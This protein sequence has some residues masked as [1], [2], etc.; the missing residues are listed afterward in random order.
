MPNPNEKLTVERQPSSFKDAAMVASI[1]A[2]KH[3]NKFT[4]G[5]SHYA[6][7][8]AAFLGAFVFAIP[9]MLAGA[10][11]ILHAFYNIMNL[12]IDTVEKRE[13][14]A[15][16]SIL[17]T[18]FIYFFGMIFG[19]FAMPFYLY[20]N[21]QKSGVLESF[22]RTYYSDENLYGNKH[23]QEQ[24][25]YKAYYYTWLSLTLIM[26]P[27]LLGAAANLTLK[28]GF[29]SEFSFTLIEPFQELMG[30]S[31]MAGN[32]LVGVL[33]MVLVSW[34]VG[35]ACKFYFGENL[36]K[37]KTYEKQNDNNHDIDADHDNTIDKKN[38][39][40]PKKKSG[41]WEAVTSW[42]F[43]DDQE[44]E[45]SVENVL[46]AVMSM[47]GLE[48]EADLKKLRVTEQYSP[49]GSEDD[50]DDLANHSIM[51]TID[52]EAVGGKEKTVVECQV[53]LGAGE[54][55]VYMN[56]SSKNQEYPVLAQIGTVNWDLPKDKRFLVPLANPA[57]TPARN[58]N[59]NEIILRTPAGQSCRSEQGTSPAVMSPV[60]SKPSNGA[61]LGSL[62]FQMQA[63]LID[64]TF[65]TSVQDDMNTGFLV[66]N[67]EQNRIEY[68]HALDEN[69]LGAKCWINNKS[70]VFIAVFD[71]RYK[72][73]TIKKD[74]NVW[75][76][77]SCLS[78][79]GASKDATPLKST[80]RL[81]T[82]MRS[83]YKTPGQTPFRTP[84]S[85]VK[86]PGPAPNPTPATAVGP[87]NTLIMAR[88]PAQ[89]QTQGA[90]RT[91]TSRVLF[92]GP[93]LTPGTPIKPG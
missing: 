90:G 61:L 73:G 68:K 21:L 80:D 6:G 13:R 93:P 59:P 60:Q 38:H 8:F 72:A 45:S 53:A 85:G 57:N 1:H 78:D 76:F 46:D 70:E 42:F 81:C 25:Y 50:E 58:V 37:D 43:G 87:G 9:N 62:N 33:L 51:L 10:R 49:G 47:L 52:A 14:I 40:T 2:G 48:S 71:G 75:V 82:P 15:V 69:S 4:A 91:T 20:A 3:I 23:A 5:V 22:K 66:R 55:A 79:V 31:G 34:V 44:G 7:I 56:Y 27:V 77:E 74:S 11:R 30:V 18:P 17:L 36:G 39:H 26:A 41:T 64:Q 67:T 83:A 35:F 16:R 12:Y 88:A 86:T 92:V 28:Y 24:N 63:K 89:R 19:F 32:A 54:V 84:A 29:N 65:M